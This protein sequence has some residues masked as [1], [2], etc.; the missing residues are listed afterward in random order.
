VAPLFKDSFR[1]HTS[2]SDDNSRMVGNPET[3]VCVFVDEESPFHSS[4]IVSAIACYRQFT[5][6]LA[7]AGYEVQ[8]FLIGEATYLQKPGAGILIRPGIDDP[9]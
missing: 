4:P 7:E 1:G 3:N 5:S 6:A 8:I 2:A 9:T